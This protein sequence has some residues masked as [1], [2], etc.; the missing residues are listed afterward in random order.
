MDVQYRQQMWPGKL[1]KFGTRRH[2]MIGAGCAAIKSAD[3]FL[4]L[5]RK[6]VPF[7]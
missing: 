4:N 1:E 5:D 6:I 3:H 7:Q 2:G